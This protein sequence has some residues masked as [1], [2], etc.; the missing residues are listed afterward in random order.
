MKQFL[1][2]SVLVLPVMPML[3]RPSVEPTPVV[4]K[5]IS[6]PGKTMTIP[7]RPEEGTTARRMPDGSIHVGCGKH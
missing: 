4:P 3:P 1:L 5:A 7:P 6:K 2:L